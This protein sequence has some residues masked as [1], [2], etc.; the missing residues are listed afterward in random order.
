MKIKKIL[1][2]LLASA[3][4]LSATI[5]SASAA[6]KELTAYAIFGMG[7]GWESQYW[8]PGE[9]D[10]TFDE[11]EIG[12]TKITEDGMHDVVLDL[13]LDG[14]EDADFDKIWV[15]KAKF[16]GLSEGD[17]VTIALKK[18]MLDDKELDIT[19]PSDFGDT[20]KPEL[21]YETLEENKEY[22][23][24]NE[25]AAK[26]IDVSN[27]DDWR[28]ASKL[29]MSFEVKGLKGDNND[30]DVPSTTDNDTTNPTTGIPASSAGLIT[31]IAATLAAGTLFKKK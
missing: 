23:V 5:L 10:N 17:N 14:F 31:L 15:V 9:D 26:L 16:E 6:E 13:N 22:N 24:Y 20:G 4:A 28:N 8:G 2:G 25:W 11:S 21:T 1:A 19:I 27:G 30:T 12:S 18:V 29:T 3:F 7:E